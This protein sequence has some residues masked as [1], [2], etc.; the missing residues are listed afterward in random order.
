MFKT[1][2]KVAK[3]WMQEAAKKMKA[4]GT[5]GSFTREAKAHGKSVGEFANEVLKE[6]SEY[7][8]KMKRKA[9]FAKA[10]KSIAE[11]HKKK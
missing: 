3:K 9:A 5:E 10:A 1:R 11:K 4:K 6:D 8:T 7:S 2:F